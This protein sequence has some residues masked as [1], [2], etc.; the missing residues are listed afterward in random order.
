[1]IGLC[2]CLKFVV[3]LSGIILS[4]GHNRLGIVF[5]QLNK[6]IQR[7]WISFISDF[8]IVTEVF[9]DWISMVSYNILTM[10]RIYIWVIEFF[11][12]FLD[13]EIW[14]R[15]RNDK[16]IMRNLVLRKRVVEVDEL[17]IFLYDAFLNVIYGSVSV[18]V[19]F[20]DYGFQRFV[21]MLNEKKMWKNSQG[22]GMGQKI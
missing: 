22:A 2:L 3:I 5:L 16:Y 7:F 15:N 11:L 6:Y 21:I 1:M 18:F 12:N 4:V 9:N 14:K 13:L 17:Y 8:A 19:S 20:L 10:F